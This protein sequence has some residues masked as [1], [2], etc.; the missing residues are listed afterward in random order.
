MN[1]WLPADF[2]HPVRVPVLDG[3][4][5]RPISG[6]DTEL[7]YPAVMGSRDR[8]WSIY[9]EAWSWPPATMTYQQDYEDLV[10]HAVEIEAHESFNYALFDE[11][12]TALLGCVYIDPAR[13]ADYEAEVS[14][15][16]VDSQVGTE[17]EQALDATVPRWLAEEWPF[18]KVALIGP[19]ITWAEWLALPDR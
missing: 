18:A 13:K 3:Y 14:W 17:L 7:D 9:G 8:L 11:A 10:R 15:W 6:E 1:P 16:V 4:H 2:V 5:L 12:E 19:E